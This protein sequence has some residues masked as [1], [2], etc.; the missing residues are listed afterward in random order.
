MTIK[1]ILLAAVVCLTG[2]ATPPV[3]PP[4]TKAV[5]SQSSQGDI[6]FEEAI[7]PPFIGMTKAQALARYGNPTTHTLR[8]DGERWGYFGYSRDSGELPLKPGFLRTGA[9]FFGPDGKVKQFSWGID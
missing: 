9:L 6:S 8:D 5:K 3:P 7:Q 2:C 1:V 4:A